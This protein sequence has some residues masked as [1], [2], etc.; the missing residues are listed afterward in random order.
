MSVELTPVV[1]V[2]SLFQEVSRIQNRSLLKL[3]L[4]HTKEF[5]NA[6]WDRNNI[7]PLIGGYIL[8]IENRDVFYPRV[9]R[10]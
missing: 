2:E 6:K 5:R 1:E 10:A 8:R 7:S 9:A 3:V 4:N